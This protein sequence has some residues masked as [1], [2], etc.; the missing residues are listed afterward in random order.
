MFVE[1]IEL[2]RCP[3]AHAESNLIAA[4]RQTTDRHIVEGTLG[5]PV[6]NAEFRIAGGV[7]R[8]DAPPPT[9]AA[10]PDAEIALKL[11]ALLDLA[12]PKGFALLT[13]AYC[14]QLDALQRLVEAA[15]VLQ[16]TPGDVGGIPAGV[17][18]CADV[19]PFAPSS[20]RAAAIDAS[21]SEAL[22]AS[23]VRCVQ[24]GGRIIGPLDMP[25]PADVNELDRDDRIW[26]GERLGRRPL[27]P[28]KRA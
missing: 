27:V 22:R 23:V 12:D 11:A 9:P 2:L 13:G 1:L 28:L 15:V 18:E 19:A 6:C 21:A 16:N 20:L 5:C 8:F 7:A 4:S 3:R 10:E 26:V 24:D 17:I 25:V 14:V